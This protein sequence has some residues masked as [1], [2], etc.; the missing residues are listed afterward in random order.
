MKTQI[1]NWLKKIMVSTSILFALML[2][3]FAQKSYALLYCDG[4]LQKLKSIIA[5]LKYSDKMMEITIG[6]TDV[7]NSNT[8]L[9][10]N[11]S[12]ANT[13]EEESLRVEPWMLSESHFINNKL[14]EDNL[15][16]VEEESIPVENWMLDES[17]FLPK[18]ESSEIT[19]VDTEEE[20]KVEDWMLDKSHFTTIAS[21]SKPGTGAY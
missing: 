18:V 10:V 1:N 6:S 5:E 16:A 21:E 13:V 11:L 19:K 17:H 2:G 3:A 8:V 4:N 20:L 9:I 12:D 7:S 15:E 14:S